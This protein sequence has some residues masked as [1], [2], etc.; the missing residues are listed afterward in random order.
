MIKNNLFYQNLL[1]MKKIYNLFILIA[2]LFFLIS[3]KNKNTNNLKENNPHYT[4][5]KIKKTGVLKVATDYN[6]INYF[7][8][9]GRPMG[10]QFELLQELSDF[11]GIKIELVAG[12][13]LKSNLKMLKN[14]EVDLVVGNIPITKSLKNDFSFTI[15]HNVSYQVLI[16]RNTSNNKV[17]N[18][19]DLKG[20]EIYT[21]NNNAIVERLKN[22]SEEIGDTIYI[23]ET[24]ETSESL[25]VKVAEGS[26]DYTVADKYL[27]QVL[28]KYYKNIDYNVE[29]SFMQN[30]GWVLR[31]DDEDL[32]HQIN[33]WLS[34]FKNTYKYKNICN[35]YLNKN[36]FHNFS[37]PENYIAERNLVSKYDKIIKK[38]CKAYGWD[39]RLIA[40]LIYQE[41][42]FRH[43]AESWAGAF[44]IMQL[45]PETAERMGV[46]RD[47]P[48][49]KHIK[50]GLE[51]LKWFYLKF[52][53]IKDENERIKFMLASYNI[54]YGHIADARK[55]AEKY[56]A[57]PNKWDNN[58]EKFLLKKSIPDYYM[59][60][61]VKYGYCRG[62]ETSNYVKSIMERYKH[63][64][65]LL[66]D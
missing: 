13:N 52:S 29:I 50:A 54:G 34:Y 2:I 8:Y 44:G 20:K 61:V 62:I 45:M 7:I 40:A 27:A 6:A 30:L 60:P 28:S 25:I 42:N 53:D 17:T 12:K 26:I 19:L 51:L 14:K 22:L 15:P 33:I 18:V 31:K 65:N 37:K 64:K 10:Y 5:E 55:L 56:G 57:N 58:V 21:P 43:D 36:N 66:H 41:S 23:H 24:D 47:D 35:K 3:C 9:K 49:E 48:P 11:M 38:Y 59:D 39:W 63:Y 1:N 46:R 32:L 4:L 16:Q